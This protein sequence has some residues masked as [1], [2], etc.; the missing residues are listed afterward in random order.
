M[1]RSFASAASGP[2]TGVSFD[3]TEDQL[4]LQTTARKFAKEEIIPVAAH[5]DRTGTP[6]LLLS[7]LGILVISECAPF[8]FLIGEYPWAVIKK[9]WEV[10]LLNTHIPQ[11]YGGLGLKLMEGALVTEELAYGW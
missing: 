11:Q 6:P 8:L 4:Q 2:S 10:G 3:L 1:T 5:H 7:L 9:A